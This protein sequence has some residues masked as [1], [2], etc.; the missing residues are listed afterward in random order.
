MLL[1]CLPLAIPWS[2]CF[3]PCLDRV[4]VSSLV[5]TDGCSSVSLSTHIS[6]YLGCSCLLLSTF[7][8]SWLV[9]VCSSACLVL[10]CSPLFSLVFF[11]PLSVIT[12][13]VFVGFPCCSFCSLSFFGVSCCSGYFLGVSFLFFV[14]C[15]HRESVWRRYV[16]VLPKY[17]GSVLHGPQRVTILYF[18]C[19]T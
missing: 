15:S 2:F 1:R 18:K 7:S 6:V 17:M 19:Q 10:A 3:F 12:F 9:P 8:C 14:L 16:D 5:F 4:P 11:V 13:S